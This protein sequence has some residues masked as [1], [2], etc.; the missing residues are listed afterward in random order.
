MT[1]FYGSSWDRYVTQT[2][3]HSRTEQSV[4]PGDEWGN[5]GLW[6]ICYD[7]LLDRAGATEW[8]RA[9]EI[10]PGSGKYTTLLLQRTRCNVLALDVSREFLRVLEERAGAYVAEGRLQAALLT[11]ARPDEVLSLVEE[12]GWRG[13]VD[14]IFSID[15]MVHVDLQYLVAYFMT[16]ALVLRPGGRLILTLADPTSARGRQKLFEDVKVYY[17]LQ[18]SPSLK[19]EWLCEDLVRSVLTSLGFVVDV[20]EHDTTNGGERDLFVIAHKGDV[21]EVTVEGY[22]R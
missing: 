12:R 5:P 17:R 8:A 9:V 18:G 10:G 21:D 6:N 22:L 11:G 16:A 19:F 20:V 13:S 1:S 4:H 7:R 3:P 2:F 14:A 15:S